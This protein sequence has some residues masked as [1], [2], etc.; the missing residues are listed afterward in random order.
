MMINMIINISER[1]RG[2]VSATVL[3]DSLNPRNM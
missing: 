3:Y 1:T 2:L